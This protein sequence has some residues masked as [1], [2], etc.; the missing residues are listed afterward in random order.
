MNEAVNSDSFMDEHYLIYSSRCVPELSEI[1]LIQILHESRIN[2]ENKG[3]SGILLFKKGH[4]L[5]VLEGNKQDI[6]DLYQNIKTDK[7]HFLCHVI[8]LEPS[9]GYQNRISKEAMSFRTEN[10]KY[11]AQFNSFMQ[12]SFNFDLLSH[13]PKTAYDLLQDLFEHEKGSKPTTLDFKQA[14]INEI[15]SKLNSMN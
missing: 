5:Q 2:N 3:I 12:P 4:F 15:K 6:I 8:C 9:G 10:S 1:E 7:R 13:Q 14:L 11:S